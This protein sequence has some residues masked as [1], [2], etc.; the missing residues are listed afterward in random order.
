ML[1]NL[2]DNF[3]QQIFK[4]NLD[5]FEELECLHKIYKIVSL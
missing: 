2:K 5:E 1:G 3:E 4:L